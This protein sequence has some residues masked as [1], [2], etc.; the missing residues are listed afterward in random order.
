VS[1]KPASS[2]EG[3]PVQP[4]I[5]SGNQNQTNKQIKQRERLCFEKKVINPKKS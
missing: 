4:E 1:L 2:I 5:V 3:V